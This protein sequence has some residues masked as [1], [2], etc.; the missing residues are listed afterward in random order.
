MTSIIFLVLISLSRLL[1]NLGLGSCSLTEICRI[2]LTIFPLP[3]DHVSLFHILQTIFKVKF[4]KE[5][6]LWHLFPLLL[7]VL[8]LLPAQ[9]ALTFLCLIPTSPQTPFYCECLVIAK[10]NVQH[11]FLISTSWLQCCT[12]DLAVQL[13]AGGQVSWSRG[14]GGLLLIEAVSC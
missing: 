3:A 11:V 14:R 7:D 2:E 6:L 8:S 10:I 4:I 5:T 13:C 1:I 12:V 9:A